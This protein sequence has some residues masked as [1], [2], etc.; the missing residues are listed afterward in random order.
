[1]IANKIE[2]KGALIEMAKKP[3]KDRHP[4]P[5]IEEITSLFRYAKTKLLTAAIPMQLKAVSYLRLC[6]IAMGK[7]Q[8]SIEILDIEYLIIEFVTDNLY[9]TLLRDLGKRHPEWWNQCWISDRGLLESEDPEIDHLLQPVVFF[10]ELFAD[11]NIN[12]FLS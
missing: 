12:L 9:S 6:C 8:Q 2:T 7:L 3:L 4:Y 10:C 11:D 1:M 5:E